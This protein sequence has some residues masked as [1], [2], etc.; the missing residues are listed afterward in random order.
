MRAV[1]SQPARKKRRHA[2]V[3]GS[4]F[5]R[6]YEA[7]FRSGSEQRRMKISVIG[8]GYVGAVSAACLARRG[9]EVVGVDVNPRKVASINDGIAPV[10]EPGLPEATAQAVESGRLRATLDAAEAVRATEVSLICVGTPSGSQG[11]LSLAALE[12]VCAD[13]GAALPHRTAQAHGRGSQHR[14]PRDQRG[15]DDPRTRGELGPGRRQGLRLRG[16][17]GVSARG[18]WGRRLRRPGE[19]G[20]RRARSAQR[21]PDR[22]DLRGPGEDDLQGADPGRGGRQV[23][24]Q[25]L[26][27]AQGGLRQRGRC[28]ERRVRD[29]L[30]SA[31]ARSSRPT[32][33]STSA[34]PI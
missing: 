14:A 21:R 1:G 29:R 19:D 24:R 4:T 33:S 26:P 28:P 8:L 9:H 31:D 25:R 5:H 23:H 20:D 3:I 6:V 12:R 22:R 34:T 7:P 17:P 10:L 15:D 32:A 30:A 13:I 11:S 27:R 16:Q 2:G 18:Q